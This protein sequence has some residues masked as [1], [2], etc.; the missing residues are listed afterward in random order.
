M[1]SPR[2][3]SSKPQPSSR[4][5][6]A[7]STVGI[8]TA[9][10]LVLADAGVADGCG[11]AGFGVG[12]PGVGS[13]VVVP[14]ACACLQLCS[15]DPVAK[16][17]QWISKPSNYDY[18]TCYLKST[19]DLQPNSASVSGCMSKGG[20]NATAKCPA[21][22]TPPPTPAPP[23][24]PA[25]PPCTTCTAFNGSHLIRPGQGAQLNAWANQTVGQK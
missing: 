20:A 3:R 10:L 1:F 6:M 15:D 18:R 24:P 11:R 25:P 17:W 13:G 12:G 23:T 14:S 21:P 9:I 5:A 7:Y 8:Y 19:V 2:S 4:F 16:A 22:P